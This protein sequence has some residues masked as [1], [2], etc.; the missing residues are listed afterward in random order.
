MDLQENALL[1]EY[2]LYKSQKS[3]IPDY[4]KIWA[5]KHSETRSVR[6]NSKRQRLAVRI[7]QS[8]FLQKE[9]LANNEKG[10]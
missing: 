9:I 8:S 10:Y 4:I 7:S 5:R 6:Q 3:Y 1:Y 2:L